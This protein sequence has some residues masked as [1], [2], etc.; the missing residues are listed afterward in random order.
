MNKNKILNICLILS[1]LLFLTP[2][3]R[4]EM[5]EGSTSGWFENP[6]GPST[7]V[8]SGNGTDTFSWGDGDMPSWI[9]F[10]GSSFSVTS[11]EVFILGTLVYHNGSIPADTGSTG[12]DLNVLLSLTTPL[13]IE[14]QFIYRMALINTLNTTDPDASADY[15]DFPDTTADSYF[16]ID[17][18][19][20][21]VELL[22]FGGLTGDGFATIEGFHVLEEAGASAQLLGRIIE[23]AEAAG[24]PPTQT[25]GD[26][27]K[28]IIPGSVP[29]RVVPIPLPVVLLGT[30]VLGV[31]ASRK[32]LFGS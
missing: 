6:S 1:W 9:N 24:P 11:N 17:G 16:S 25:K 29:A 3:L 31:M 14:D 18:I 4:A 15:V 30:G 28:D 13:G 7:M 23:F 21:T 10:T 22:G 5:I 12:V 26:F 20:Y 27:E 2:N 32:K 19:N 8:V